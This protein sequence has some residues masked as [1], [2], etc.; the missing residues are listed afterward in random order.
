MKVADPQMHDPDARF[1]PFG[2]KQ[3]RLDGSERLTAKR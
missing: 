2:R 1:T 3:M